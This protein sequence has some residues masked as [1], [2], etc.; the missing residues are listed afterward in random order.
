M[1][2]FLLV[3]SVAL[4]SAAGPSIKLSDVGYPAATITYKAGVLTVPQHCRAKCSTLASADQVAGLQAMGLDH[5]E[6]IA[7]LEGANTAQAAFIVAQA[8]ENKALGDRITALAT[9][10]TA[11]ATKHGDDIKDSDDADA[12]FA[13]ADATLA[14]AVEAVAKLEGPKGDTGA[15][16]A[17]GAPGAKGA[18][19]TDGTDGADGNDG[20]KGAKGDKGD[21]GPAGA[22]A[23]L[24]GCPKDVSYF[25]ATTFRCIACGSCARDIWGRPCEGGHGLGSKYC[26]GARSGYFRTGCG[27][28]NQGTCQK[29]YDHRRYGCASQIP[30]CKSYCCGNRP[31]PQ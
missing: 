22:P 3:A 7:A 10:L 16:G 11:L 31:C 18:D 28:M 20:D 25:D 9:K 26:K 19:G 21:K 17:E 12:A 27:G 5:I 15:A 23:A 2:C 13:A 8:A 24:K 1:K 29:C 4:A 14:A 6:R 30:Q